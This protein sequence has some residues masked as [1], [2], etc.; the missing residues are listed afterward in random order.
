MPQST[1]RPSPSGRDFTSTRRG[2]PGVFVLV[3]DYLR[4]RDGEPEGFTDPRQPLSRYSGTNGRP[5]GLSVGGAVG[6]GGL[7]VVPTNNVSI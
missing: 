5:V 7:G 2:R 6:T 4:G 1:R 3:W